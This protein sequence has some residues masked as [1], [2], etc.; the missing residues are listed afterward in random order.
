MSRV[1]TCY[2]ASLSIAVARALG[3]PHKLSP[4][5]SSLLEPIPLDA[6]R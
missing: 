6:V 1:F 3:R 4:N 5:V 2:A